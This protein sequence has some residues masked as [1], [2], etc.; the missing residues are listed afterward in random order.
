MGRGTAPLGVLP[1]NQN[2]KLPGN[3]AIHPDPGGRVV[4]HQA[5]S[6]V[7]TLKLTSVFGP[8]VWVIGTSD[9]SRPWAINI[10]PIRG[11]LLR[12]SKVCQRPPTK[13]SNQP[14]KS[15]GP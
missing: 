11:T 4:R 14:A 8:N 7:Q 2:P 6:S 12:G 3:G 10:R 1:R 15:P 13:A 9:A 5:T